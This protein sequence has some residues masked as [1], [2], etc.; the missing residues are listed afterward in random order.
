MSVSVPPNRFEIET[1]ADYGKVPSNAQIQPTPFKS[2]IPEEKL[3]EFK[4][5]IKL[6]PIGPATYE[7]Q[8]ADRRWGM[9]RQWLVDAK[10]YWESEYDW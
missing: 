3:A 4:Q 10:K 1:M 6:S 8:Q 9:N 7:N 5:L 2:A